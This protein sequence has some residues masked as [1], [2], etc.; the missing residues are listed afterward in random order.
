MRKQQIKKE[1]KKDSSSSSFK[2]EMFSS[3]NSSSKERK[4]EE[5]KKIHGILKKRR[6]LPDI[7]DD[8]PTNS[9]DGSKATGRNFI[10]LKEE[11]IM[12]RTLMGQKWLGAT[13]YESRTPKA[14]RSDSR[15]PTAANRRDSRTPI[16][17]RPDSH[18]PTGSRPTRSLFNGRET[19]T[20]K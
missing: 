18:T 12:V 9:V 11:E 20:P 6:A 10:R 15:T 14:G 16:A 8:S 1:K 3:S 19:P 13:E 2:S 5:A 17:A 7:S 4:G